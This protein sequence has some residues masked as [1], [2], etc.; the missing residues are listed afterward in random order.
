MMSNSKGELSGS[1]AEDCPSAQ[2]PESNK[3]EATEKLSPEEE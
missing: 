3:Y 1:V 2:V